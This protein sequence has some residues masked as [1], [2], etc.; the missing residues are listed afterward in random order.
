MTSITHGYGSTAS[1]TSSKAPSTPCSCASSRRAWSTSTVPSEEGP[2]RK[3]YS[4]NP[5]GQD[6][7]EEFW[8]LELPGRTPAAAALPSRRHQSVIGC[9][10]SPWDLWLRA[11]GM[12]KLLRWPTPRRVGT[13][14]TS[15][16]LHGG[17]ASETAPARCSSRDLHLCEVSRV[18]GMRASGDCR[19]IWVPAEN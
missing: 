2:P 1:P 19:R 6:Q 17:L 5:P 12:G 9:E 14:G 11:W 10:S 3:V 15:R 8:D 16:L 18:A 13:D 7:L 4:P